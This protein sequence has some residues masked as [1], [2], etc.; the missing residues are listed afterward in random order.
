MALRERA[1]DLEVCITTLLQPKPLTKALSNRYNPMKTLTKPSKTPNDTP[2]KSA[3]E[4]Q[5]HTLLES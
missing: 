5:A 4:T 2:R 1:F 3:V